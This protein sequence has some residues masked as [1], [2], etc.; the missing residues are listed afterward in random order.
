MENKH[1]EYEA[2]HF[3]RDFISGAFRGSL[4]GFCYGLIMG[5]Y[6]TYNPELPFNEFSRKWAKYT[7]RSSVTF[8]PLLGMSSVTYKFCQSQEM[9]EFNSMFMTIVV[10]GVLFEL[11]KKFIR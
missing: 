6:Q 1:Y 9:S 2:K 4:L 10:T 11:G 7:I 5:A 3:K 8:M